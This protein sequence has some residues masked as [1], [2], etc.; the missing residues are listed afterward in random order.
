[1]FSPLSP[2]ALHGV[3]LAIGGLSEKPVAGTEIAPPVGQS[4]AS[5]SG[6]KLKPMKIISAIINARKRIP[7]AL[8]PRG[9]EAVLL[10]YLMIRFITT[11]STA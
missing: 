7:L 4:A 9:I 3:L 11:P 6:L 1:M 5:G 10:E 2:H 8:P